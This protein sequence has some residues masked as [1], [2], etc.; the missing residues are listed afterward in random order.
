VT[1]AVLEDYQ[2]AAAAQPYWARLEGRARVDFFHDAL[3]GDAEV[4][5]R[6]RAYPIVVPIRERT[7]F[8]AA[9]LERLPALE[10]LALTG[11]NSG[12]ADV[13]AAT[14]DLRFTYAMYLSPCVFN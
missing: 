13:A 2:G 4:V 6:L 9:V 5:D 7:R 11:R 12:H 14:S 10:L 3:A 8:P 1:V